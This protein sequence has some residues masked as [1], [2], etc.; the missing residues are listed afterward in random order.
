MKTTILSGSEL[1][2]KSFPRQLL[3]HRQ[4]AG[5]NREFLPFVLLSKKLVPGRRISS[6]LIDASLNAPVGFRR[7]PERE[8]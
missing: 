6:L 1:F 2:C 4:S 5:G 7:G 3:R 8:E